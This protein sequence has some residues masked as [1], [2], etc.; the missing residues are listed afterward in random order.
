MTDQLKSILE[1]GVD[2]TN[3]R[4]YLLGEID[5]RM[6]GK[7][8]I[9]IRKLDETEGDITIILSSGGG[10]EYSG[11][12]IY[13][14][15]MSVK[16]KVIIECMG[17]CESIAMTILQAGDVRVAHPLTMFMIHN[18]EITLSS[19]SVKHNEIMDRFKE[20]SKDNIK[21]Y[22]ILSNNSK[23]SFK[24]IE[25]LC[26]EDSYFTS[27]EALKCRFIDKILKHNKK[28]KRKFK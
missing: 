19:D 7:F 9:S 20:I 27:E 25:E 11:Y 28:G 2:E 18:G 26:K 4:I 16:N 12:S 1:S 22:N 5:A 17:H 15:I 10:E 6:A 13:D 21:Y 14:T 23:L 24:E 8:L 3:R